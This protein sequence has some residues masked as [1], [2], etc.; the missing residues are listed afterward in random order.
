MGGL[1]DKTCSPFFIAC[2]NSK[3]YKSLDS[4]I[5]PAHQ[6]DPADDMQTDGRLACEDI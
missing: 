6:T 1:R 2:L 5:N 3:V 4:G